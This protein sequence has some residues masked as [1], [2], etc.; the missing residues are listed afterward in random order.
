M[1]VSEEK[2]FGVVE[3]IEYLNIFFKKQNV[4]ITGE[5]SDLKRAASGHVYFTLKDKKDGGVL[6]SIIWSRNYQMC[7]VTLEV[8]MEVI[9]FGHPNVYPA[10]G[11][12][13]VRGG[14]G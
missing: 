9:L 7:G 8:G 4:R 6:D 5:I 12:L 2:I 10:S 13:V 1:K 14:Y 3:F 11:R